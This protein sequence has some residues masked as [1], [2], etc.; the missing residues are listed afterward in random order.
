MGLL[1][2]LRLSPFPTWALLSAIVLS[3]MVIATV[4]VILLLAVGRL[5]FSVHFPDNVGAFVVAILVGMLCF[6]AL[7]LAMSTL[8]PNQDAAGPM[9]SIIFFVLLFLS[10]L[11]FPIRP[12]S[13][14]AQFSS[15]FPVRH[16]IAAV[17]APFDTQKGASP[18]AW[19]DLL[20]V[21][22]WGVVG[23]FVAVRRWKWSP[24]RG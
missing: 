5:G 6:S 8:V 17:F 22:I 16:L 20:V 23:A 24:R 19:H 9:I 1:K 14:L 18:W 7:G 2:R 10:G 21:A 4:E 3:S 11:W 15:Y 12:G 13:G